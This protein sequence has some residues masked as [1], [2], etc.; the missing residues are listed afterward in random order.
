I[1]IEY[2]YLMYNYTEVDGLSVG[3]DGTLILVARIWDAINDPIM[4]RIV[5][6]T[7]SRRGKFKPWILNGTKAKSEFLFLLF[8]AHRYE[9]TTQ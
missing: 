5:N 7:R 2:M 3:L 4:G 9:G 6:A 1:G 8:S